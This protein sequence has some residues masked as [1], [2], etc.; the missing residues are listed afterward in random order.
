M[1][2]HV[3]HNI[4]T[5]STHSL[6]F[7]SLSN[8]VSLHDTGAPF[9][10]V[11]PLKLASLCSTS[12]HLVQSFDFRGSQVSLIRALAKGLHVPKFYS[13]GCG[14]SAPLSLIQP[15]RGRRDTGIDSAKSH[16]V[17]SLLHHR[18]ELHKRT[19]YPR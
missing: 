10:V 13:F 2:H 4:T 16:V 5:S 3:E 9:D 11:I 15:A 14:Y 7:D 19:A 6:L 8:D 12:A 18:I 1:S 17:F